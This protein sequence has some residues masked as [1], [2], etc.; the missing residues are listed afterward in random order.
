MATR[1]AGEEEG[2]VG[3]GDGN[4]NEETTTRRQRDDVMTT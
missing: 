3:K 1:V 2:K 4:G